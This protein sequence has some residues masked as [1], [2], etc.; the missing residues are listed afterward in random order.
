MSD[1]SEIDL[2][3]ARGNWKFF[4][5]E[6]FVL[7]FLD[8]NNNWE[9]AGNVN[10]RPYQN[11]RKNT[12]RIEKIPKLIYEVPKTVKY[13]FFFKWPTV[14]KQP[15]VLSTAILI[16]CITFLLFVSISI[17]F[18]LNL[19][20]QLRL[21]Y[22]YSVCNTELLIQRQK[23][24]TWRHRRHLLGAGIPVYLV[25]QWSHQTKHARHSSADWEKEAGKPKLQEPGCTVH[26]IWH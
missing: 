13:Y 25:E 24:R 23:R 18:Q 7:Q 19:D 8:F 10:L 11:N 22:Q 3:C 14:L 21:S 6:I 1:R 17:A 26:S 5:S 15:L 9:A 12:E 2:R 20:D 16:I 4:H